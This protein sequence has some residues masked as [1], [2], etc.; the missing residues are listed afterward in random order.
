MEVVGEAEDAAAAAECLKSSPP[1]IA[2]VD[3][4]NLSSFDHPQVTVSGTVGSAA[5]EVRCNGVVADRDG[6]FHVARPAGAPR[7]DTDA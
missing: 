5:I 2:I 3:P 4:P 6:G 1:T 7:N